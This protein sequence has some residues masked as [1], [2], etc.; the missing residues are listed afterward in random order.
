MHVVL[1]ESIHAICSTILAIYRIA[2]DKLIV[3]FIG[4]TL[5]ILILCTVIMIEFVYTVIMIA[6]HL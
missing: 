6:L 1:S 2:L 5:T 4:E 3:G